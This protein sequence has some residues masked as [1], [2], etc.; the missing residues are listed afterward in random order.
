MR[1]QLHAPTNEHPSRAMCLSNLGISLHKRFEQT[2]F[3]EDLDR[4]ITMN[5]K[6]VASRPIDHPDRSAL[7]CHLAGTLLRRFLKT[8]STDYV[9]RAIITYEHAF[10][11]ETSPPSVR[12]KA[13][14]LCSD[15]LIG[16][17]AYNRARP[18]LCAAV[19][20][21][22][23]VSPRT[24][25]RSDQQYHISQFSH[26]TRRAVSLSRVDANDLYESLQLL[27]L[28][29]GIL[30]NL[31]LEVRSD[32]SL[33]AECHS[34]HA[35]KFQEL[36][37]QIDSPSPTSGSSSGMANSPVMFDSPSAQE[38]IKF[39]SKRHALVK[40]FDDLLTSIR[41]LDG[42]ETFLRGPSKAELHDLAKRGP[43]VVFNVSDIRS[44]AFI[45]TPSEIRSLCLPLLSLDSLKDSA[46]RFVER[47]RQPKFKS[48]TNIRGKK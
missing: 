4:A 34:S 11:A 6:A 13:A 24:L 48:I 27:E 41:L 44:D 10:A 20:L 43:I 1:K 38:S 29:R 5:E 22:P 36:R 30:A 31:Q 21:L 39:I 12:L 17:K 18:I 46:N 40:E 32:I 42:F 16:L 45:V 7:L 28:G 47:N 15:I 19:R 23:M 33:L 26:I 3:T 37:D 14:S 9:N 2:G 25:D 35:K 8:G